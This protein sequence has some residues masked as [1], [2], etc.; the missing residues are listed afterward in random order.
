MLSLFYF[1]KK[2]GPTPL[3][4]D[5][6]SSQELLEKKE[7]WFEEW[8]LPREVGKMNCSFSVQEK[9]GRLLY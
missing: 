8:S 9:K 6:G 4:G 1:T 7:V 5:K 2:R 3:V